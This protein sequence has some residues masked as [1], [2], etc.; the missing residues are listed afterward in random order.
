MHFKKSALMALVVVALGIVSCTQEDEV[1]N[2]QTSEE[3]ASDGDITVLEENVVNGQELFSDAM[4]GME[5][6][7]GSEAYDALKEAFNKADNSNADAQTRGISLGLYK[8]V[9]VEYTTTDQDMKPVKASALI[10]YPILKK[11][12]QV[13]L[14][15]HGTQVGFMMVPTKFTSAEA[16][17]AATGSLCIMPDYIGLGSTSNHADLYLNHDVHG[18]TSVD[19]LL[20]L[21]DYAKDKKLNLDSN[22]KTTILGY[23]QG[24]SVSLASLREVQR[25]DKATQAR[26]RLDK[27]FC[28]DGPY[29]LS[30]TFQT[31]IEDYEQ[32][33]KMGL[34]AVIPM[35]INS[36]FNSY[37]TEMGI[38]NY[39]DFFTDKCWKTGVPQAIRE[40]REGVLDV[41]AKLNGWKL[42][43]ILNFDY[44]NAQPEALETLIRMM[45]RQNLCKGW[46]PEYKLKLLH[47]NPD[48]VVPF[49]NYEEAVKYLMN[50]KVTT[51]EV[52][53]NTNLI[54]DPLLQ[55]VYGMLVMLKEV[56]ADEY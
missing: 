41:V 35:V 11:I 47:C 54:S 46:T 36:M 51:E 44:C 29:D 49:S 37:P 50:D 19:A 20:T 6:L 34:G 9:K 17:M 25:R 16:I 15:N 55:H 45:D 12:K 22:Y 7:K 27:V 31:Y 4:S 2:V 5:Q 38:Y 26:I 39:R 48:G 8:T 32:G 24:G 21:L 33:K 40:N 52:S 53:I 28:G 56:F 10:V 13:M 42:G 1:L 18:R 3:I 23:S 30:R 14:I 43:E